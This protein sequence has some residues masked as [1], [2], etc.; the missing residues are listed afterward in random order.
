MHALIVEDES[1]TAWLIEEELRDLGFTSVETAATEEDAVAAAEQQ[2][3]DL[4]TSDG[5]LQQ[6]GGLSAVQ[7]I[8]A[9]TPIPV[10]FI[11]GEVPATCDLPLGAIVLEKPFAARHLVS[12]VISL[13][14]GLDQRCP[15]SPTFSDAE[16]A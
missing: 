13:I 5:R 7:R 2:R 3:P 4:I 1:L 10:I 15:S 6:G 16:A 8:C 9:R 12:A 14:P 11:T